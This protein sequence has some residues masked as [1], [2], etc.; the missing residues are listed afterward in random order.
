MAAKLITDFR[1]F[2]GFLFTILREY[3]DK[4]GGY[5]GCLSWYRSSS[6]KLVGICIQMP[7]IPAANKE[8]LTEERTMP[9]KIREA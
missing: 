9:Y 3:P 4:I 6:L 5:H 1:K 7:A 8:T 2:W